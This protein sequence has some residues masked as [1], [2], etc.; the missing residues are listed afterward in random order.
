[1]NYVRLS[2]EG[3][4]TK[5]EISPFDCNLASKISKKAQYGPQTKI[6]GHYWS[7]EVAIVKQ[8]TIQYCNEPLRVV[9][10]FQRDL[11]LHYG[12]EH[13]YCLTLYKLAKER[14][15]VQQSKPVSP[16]EGNLK[17]ANPPDR[18]NSHSEDDDVRK[19]VK[20]SAP[21]PKPVSLTAQVH[22]YH[23]TFESLISYFP[24]YDYTVS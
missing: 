4:Y 13:N 18:R 6:V 14:K 24:S 19:P 23:F 10:I 3:Q 16:C 15:A 21:L 8:N 20:L 1:M 9:S 2:H 22:R 7:I 12:C 17:P 11:L 5:L